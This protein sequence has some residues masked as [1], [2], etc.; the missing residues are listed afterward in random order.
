MS[1]SLADALLTISGHP[2]CATVDVEQGDDDSL[3]FYI[4]DGDTADGVRDYDL[5]ATLALYD[6]AGTTYR[7]TVLLPRPT[8]AGD[9]EPDGWQ[10]PTVSERTSFACR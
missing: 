4:E 5:E 9:S 8:D 1:D 3:S 2:L 6:Q 7:L 10:A